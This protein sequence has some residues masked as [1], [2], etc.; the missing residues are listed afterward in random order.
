MSII[1]ISKIQV[2]SGNIADLPQL[3]VGELGMA[4]DTNQVFIGTD[5]NISISPSPQNIE[6]L[7]EYNIASGATGPV[8]P[9]GATGATGIQ[10]PAGTSVVIIGGIA[11]VGGDPQAALDAAFPD[12]VDGN[13]VLAED[14]GD[15][16]V[17]TAGTWINV[18]NIQG[19]TGSTGP[20]GSTGPIGPTG[21]TGPTGIQGATGPQGNIGAT[22]T[23]GIGGAYTYTQAS[24]NAQA[25]WNVNH[26]L[27]YQYLNVEV[28]DSTGN[29]FNG[30]YDYP[31]I[32]FVDANNLTITF[33]TAQTGWAAVTSGGGQ[34]GATGPAGS[35]VNI[36][37]S[38]PTTSPDPQT[39]LDTAFP[40]AVDGN[41]VIDEAAGDLWVLSGGTW[42]NVGAIQGATGPQGATGVD[43]PQG[44]TGPQ[45]IQ[46]ATGPTGPAGA[47]GAG[48]TGAEGATGPTGATGPAGATGA[49]STGATG[50]AGATGPQGATGLTGSG[51]ALGYWGSFWDTTATQEATTTTDSYVISIG[52]S[53]PA[54]TGVSIT[55]GTRLTFAHTGVYNIQYSLQFTN[56]D[57][58]N[59]NNNVDVW[60]RKNGVDVPDTNSV[61]ALP[62]SAGGVDGK[63]IAAV[64]Y[65]LSLTAGDYIEFV[66]ATTDIDI[67]LETI[68]AGS[69][70][71]VPE[72]PCA[73]ITAQQVMYTQIG[74]TGA[75]GVQGSPGTVGAT[76]SEG[77]QGATGLTGP[78]GATGIG[79]TGPQGATGPAGAT[80]PTGATGPI[81][82]ANTQVI[83]NDS[84]VAA[85]SANFTFDTTANTLTVVGTANIANINAT[86]NL[87]ANNMTSNN[88]VVIGGFTITA[89]GANAKLVFSYGGSNIFSLDSTGNATAANNITAFGTP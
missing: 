26:G 44:A 72:S 8:G 79:A 62:N 24:G 2:R 18:G 23:A 45:G 19:P 80:G 46:G 1:Q 38:V 22:G 78:E 50:V 69:T 43:G 55:S 14:T 6:L 63:L 51:G 77:P 56:A 75:T 52:Q 88:V 70:P 84:N 9:R 65:M 57:T 53:D 71:T 76:G 13:G 36:I 21:S 58:G 39:I 49:G 3:A 48:A 60:I 4:V 73:I 7:T 30:R 35:S 11:T 86:G 12:A 83:F 28:V 27:G 82:G 67:Y 85:G 20:Q 40:G 31:T 66:W 10:G 74:P 32:D 41:G 54:S 64:N 68:P 34:V 25:V 33:A 16:W 59:S 37:G 17:L 87:I 42:I 89:D 5:A 29:S 81:G 47:T 15:L 61:Y